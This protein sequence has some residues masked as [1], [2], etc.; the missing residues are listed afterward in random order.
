M[1]RSVR[2]PCVNISKALREAGVMRVDW[3]KTDSQGIDLRLFQSLGEA[4]CLRTLAVEFEPGIIDA[5]EG[6]DKLS[7]VLAAMDRGEFWLSD[8]TLRG[9]L[10]MSPEDAA[11]FAGQDTTRLADVLPTAPGWGEM[12]LS[13]YVSG[14]GPFSKRDWLLG[15]VIAC[16]NEQ[17]GFASRFVPT[18]GRGRAG[19]GVRRAGSRHREND[20]AKAQQRS[21]RRSRPRFHPWN[22]VGRTLAVEARK[23]TAEQSSQPHD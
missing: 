21:C 12:R 16:L 2:V 9:T 22:A 20:P 6:E 18:R 4:L 13:Q 8:L 3:F 19:S 10:R 5:Y 1:E 11:R 15:W 7:A 14:A 17:F 23:M